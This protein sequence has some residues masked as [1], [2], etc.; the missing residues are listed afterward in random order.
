[1]L[2]LLRLQ[3]RLKEVLNEMLGPV[4][5]SPATHGAAAAAGRGWEPTVMGLDKRLMLRYV[6][7]HACII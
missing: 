2:P 5:W 7:V 3:A 1:L 6:C 4:R